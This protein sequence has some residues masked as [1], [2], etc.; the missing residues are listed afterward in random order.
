MRKIENKL[1]KTRLVCL[2]AAAVFIATAIIPLTSAGYYRTVTYKV[3]FTPS[4]LFFMF[5]PFTEV[6]G[7]DAI[8][9]YYWE[10]RQIWVQTVPTIPE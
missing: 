5:H 2:F 6:D 4:V 9:Y 7:M 10:T 1:N 8:G 3:Y